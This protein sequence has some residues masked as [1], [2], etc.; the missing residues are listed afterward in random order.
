MI[1]YNHRD[2]SRGLHDT[3]SEIYV[4]CDCRRCEV[5]ARDSWYYYDEPG[6]AYLLADDRLALPAG[7]MVLLREL[8]RRPPC[9]VSL[10]SKKTPGWW[11]Y[12]IRLEPSSRRGSLSGPR[13]SAGFRLQLRRYGHVGRNRC[14]RSRISYDRNASGCSPRR[15][16]LRSRHPAAVIDR[17]L[18]LGSGAVDLSA[19]RR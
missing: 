11:L 12:S 17:G 15:P 8:K 18:S 2:H 3:I 7:V 10:H 5:A 9:A 16:S 4:N 13:L 14:A 1:R 19:L 6:R